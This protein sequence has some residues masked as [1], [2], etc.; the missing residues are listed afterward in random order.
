MYICV[1]I[2][3]K[4]LTYTVMNAEEPQNLQV[5]I[6]ILHRTDSVILVCIP[7]YKCSKVQVLCSSLCSQFRESGRCREVHFSPQ[8][9]CSIHVLVDWIWHLH[10]KKYI[11]FSLSTNSI[12]DHLIPVHVLSS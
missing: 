10:G 5:T 7:R 6:L 8:S 3:Y 2:Y 9:L 12:I 4:E 11:D 1:F